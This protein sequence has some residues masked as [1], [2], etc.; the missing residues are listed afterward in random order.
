MNIREPQPL[1]KLPAVSGAM[2]RGRIACRPKPTIAADAVHSGRWPALCCRQCGRRSDAA[3]QN[4]ESLAAATGQP[5]L[6]A[7]GGIHDG[8][9]SFRYRR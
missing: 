7:A 8:F 6:T 3:Q 1:K 4:C 2:S 5:V 9:Q